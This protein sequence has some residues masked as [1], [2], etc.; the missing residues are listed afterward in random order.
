MPAL[1]LDSRPLSLTPGLCP[2]LQASVRRHAQ[3]LAVLLAP[4][5]F[6]SC[7]LWG[8]A[9]L[10]RC[11]QA[12]VPTHPTHLLLSAQGWKASPA[13]RTRSCW[14]RIE[15]QLKR[16]FAIG[17]QVPCYCIIQAP[18]KQVG[19]QAGSHHPVPCPALSRQAWDGVGRLC[20][21]QACPQCSPPFDFLCR[22]K[23]KGPGLRFCW[24]PPRL[25]PALCLLPYLPPLWVGVQNQRGE[26]SSPLGTELLIP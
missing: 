16:R 12:E 22:I 15:K 8:L 14:L 7:S 3:A 9:G 18:T 21:A 23:G 4:S 10:F 25:P 13:R 19:L 17:S 5:V 6:L 2:R 26:P 11:G 1:S 20:L 24:D